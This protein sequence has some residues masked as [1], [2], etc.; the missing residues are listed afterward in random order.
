M[1]FLSYTATRKFLAKLSEAKT[2]SC[3]VN[4]YIVQ[5]LGAG[6]LRWAVSEGLVPIQWGW[7]Q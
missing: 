4:N 6:E 2:N 3:A 7:V 5:R 1:D